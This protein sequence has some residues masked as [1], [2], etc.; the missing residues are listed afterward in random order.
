MGS[1]KNGFTLN[2][3]VLIIIIVAIVAAVAVTQ[4]PDMEGMRISQ[5]AYK[6][7]S[8]I[9]YTQR[10]A[11]QL[12]RR[13]AILFSAAND[14]YSIYIENTYGADDWDFNNVKAKDPLTQ[15]DFDVQLN[16]DEFAGV[17]ITTVVF[18]TAN[19]ALMFDRNGD[20]YGMQ[21]TSPFTE[22]ALSDPARVVLNTDQKYIVVKQGTGR[23]NVQ[24]TAP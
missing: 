15:G 16:A 11:M 14:D 3:F 7:Q 4:A 24:D 8:D 19:Y 23:V 1:N 21:P 9:R 20:P 6:I 18:N 10:L 22:S 2:E 17:D 13:T 5:A 12:Q